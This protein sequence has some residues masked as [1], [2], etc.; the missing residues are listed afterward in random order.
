[1][2]KNSV[3]LLHDAGQ[4]YVSRCTDKPVPA[5]NVGQPCR[6][7]C[8]SRLGRPVVEAL[9]NGFYGMGDYDKQ[10]AYIQS[11]VTTN[12]VKR[13]R[14][15]IGEE[16]PRKGK[17]YAY[18]VKYDNVMHK[19]C[20]KGFLSIFAITDKRV[21][22]ALKKKTMTGTPIS[23]QRGKHTPANK[24]SDRVHVLIKEH[25]D[26]VPKVSSHYT[27]ARSADR[28]YF[29]TELNMAIL[30][31][32]HRD[33]M[34]ENYPDD[35][36]VKESFYR[37]AVNVKFNVGF[38]PVR[39][40]TCNTCDLFTNQIKTLK[41]SAASE[42]VISGLEEQLAEHRT[43]GN[44]GQNFIARFKGGPFDNDGTLALCFDLQQTLPTPKLAHGAAYYL[45][46]LWTFNFC[47]TNMRSNVSTMFVWDEVTGKRGSNDIASCLLKYLDL[48]HDADEQTQLFL[49]SDNCSGQNKNVNVSLLLLKLIHD[50]KFFNIQHH[51][52]VPGHSY[53]PCDRH[54]G[55]I[56]QKLRK[57]ATIETRDDYIRLIKDATHEGFEVIAMQ[58]EDFLDFEVLQ[59][60]ITKRTPRGTTFSN[61][62]IVKYD[63][64]Y[65]EG[66][67]VKDTYS[68]DE[69]FEKVRLQKGKQCFSRDVFD[70]SKVPLTPRYHG[71]IKIKPVKVKELKELLPYV[72]AGAR[73]GIMMP[74]LPNR[75]PCSKRD[76]GQGKKMKMRVTRRTIC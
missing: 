13:R 28:K 72:S 2:E 73:H 23:D 18:C 21:I 47:V 38:A 16:L 35:E 22:T 31:Q 60:H 65:R 39:T 12:P 5:R 76:Q 55:N 45:R 62:R 19:V 54:F 75:K 17:T 24:L 7:G 15:P 29:S 49:L 57:Y 63:C 26:S 30:Y 9:F 50:K 36:K 32:L 3:K 1:M 74:L 58:R 59:Y 61:S 11:L 48:H 4:E 42:D 66:Y 25:V 41:D 8:F 56:E 69:A 46:K 27:R 51:F 43:L 53:M 71:P 34:T 44:Q 14:V 20:K 10:T 33:W 64:S 37:N 67:Q 68:S 40:D 52:L 70:L 6:D